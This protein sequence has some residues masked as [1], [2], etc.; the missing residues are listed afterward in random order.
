MVPLWTAIFLPARSS[1][2]FTPEP[3]GTTIAC[4]ASKYGLEKSSTR[5]RSPVIVI[6]E[7]ATSHVPVLSELAGRDGVEVRVRT[8]GSAPAASATSSTRSTS[9]P[10]GSPPFIDSNGS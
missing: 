5:A 2:V 4:A 1:S 8:T 10:T 9:K 7:I 6:A 3:L